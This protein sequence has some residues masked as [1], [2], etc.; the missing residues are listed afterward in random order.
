MQTKFELLEKLRLRCSGPDN[1]IAT[2]KLTIK[3]CGKDD[4][5]PVANNNVLPILIHSCPDDFSTVE[6]FD[7]RKYN[8]IKLLTLRYTRFVYS[9]LKRSILDDWSS[10]H[11]L[12]AV[13]CMS[14]TTWNSS[15]A[16]LCCPCNRPLEWVAVIIRLVF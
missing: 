14:S 10:M 1:V 13:L 9:I 6:Y 8:L 12:S 4:K 7:V 16:W 2:P 3:F 5:P 11:R 15:M